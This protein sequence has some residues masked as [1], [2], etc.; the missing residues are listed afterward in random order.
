MLIIID[1]QYHL[2][3]VRY[4]L[5]LIPVK[6]PDILEIVLFIFLPT[7]KKVGNMV[8]KYLILGI[9]DRIY[10][11]VVDMRGALSIMKVLIMRLWVN[12]G[13]EIIKILVILIHP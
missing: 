6:L 1:I 5:R 7:L 9:M 11:Q 4:L 13:L 2:V 3:A 8:L 12:M 10:P